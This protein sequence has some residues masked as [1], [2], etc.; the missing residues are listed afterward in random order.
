M[1]I[2]ANKALVRRYLELWN[3]EELAIAD[4]IIAAHF[5]DHTHPELAPGPEDV[6]R[7]V[8]NFRAAFPDA[9]ARVEQMIGEG[10][11]VAFRF[12]LRGTHKDQFGRFPPTGK[13]VVLTGMDLIRITDG[14]LVELWSSQDTFTFALQLGLKIQQP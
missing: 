10:D 1:D 8:K 3:S 11:L 6:K 13:E 5:V 2:E 9:R 12:E 14:K 7:E 4:E